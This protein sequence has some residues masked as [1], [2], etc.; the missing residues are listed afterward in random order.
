MPPVKK[1]KSNSGWAD[2]NLDFSTDEVEQIKLNDCKKIIKRTSAST[3]VNINNE[4]ESVFKKR[5]KQGN[6]LATLLE[7]CDP[8]EP[9]HLSVSKRKQNELSDWLYQQKIQAGKPRILIL[10]GPSGCGKTV[11]LKVL[12]KENNFEV[13]EW[14]TPSDSGIYENYTVSKQADK[15]LEFLIRTT[16]YNSVLEN[17]RSSRRLL[18]VKDIPNVYFFNKDSFHQLLIDYLEL[19]R[20]PLVF[21][22]PDSEGSRVQFSLFPTDI[23]EKFNI[24]IINVNATTSTAMKNM[25]K[26]VSTILNDKGGHLLNITQ[27]SID[28]VLSNG[29]G[30]V[31]STLLNIIFTSLKVPVDNK[32]KSDCG[33]RGESLGLLHGIGRVINPKRIYDGKLWKF[34]HDPD[35]IAAYF[36]SQASIFLHF[37]HE[38]Y[39]NTMGKI[40]QVDYCSDIMSLSD[41]I[42]TEWRDPNLLK[43]NLSLCIRG[44][45]VLNE[46]PVTQWNPVRKPK[47]IEF[48]SQ[49]DLG[50]AEERWYKSIIRPKPSQEQNNLDNSI[51]IVDD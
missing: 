7:A 5:N 34:S 2:L 21:I 11:T 44:A 38:N 20:E 32:L 30:D 35:E 42:S 43:V 36:Q 6:S 29:I 25:L 15:F 22:C 14:I 28:E 10:S 13:I 46:N 3:V 48:K 17:D 4:F 39:L 33:L 40:E 1:M 51:E 50:V 18:L 37:L 49:R 8:T 23:I 26:R 41:T 19:G 47:S 24:D 45:M 9:S 16:R 31:R 12:A 27:H